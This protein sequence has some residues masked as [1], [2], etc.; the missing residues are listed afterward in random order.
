MFLSQFCKFPC[1]YNP[2]R[3]H[4][5]F[6]LILVFFLF[7]YVC[8]I[9]RIKHALRV[10]HHLLKDGKALTPVATLGRIR[11][12]K[13]WQLASMMSDTTVAHV[14]LHFSSDRALSACIHSF[15]ISSVLLL[16]MCYSTCVLL[17][18]I[19]R[20]CWCGFRWCALPLLGIPFFMW[21]C[22]FQITHKYPTLF[23]ACQSIISV[24]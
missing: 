3:L 6:Y 17:G 1:F 9:L 5:H 12:K 2:L 16:S 20:F 19:E 24:T 22:L 8:E 7:I 21:I 13:E 10:S 23:L 15:F 4:I 11:R 14:E 18:W